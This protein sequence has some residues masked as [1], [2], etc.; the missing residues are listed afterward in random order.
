[1][2]TYFECLLCDRK[3]GTSTFG[4]PGKDT[5]ECGKKPPWRPFSRTRLKFIYLDSKSPQSSNTGD[6]TK[7]EPLLPHVGTTA[8]VTEGKRQDSRASQPISSAMN[9]HVQRGYP[10]NDKIHRGHQPPANDIPAQSSNS[11]INQYLTPM[12]LVFSRAVNAMIL[13]KIDTNI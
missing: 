2:S 3:Q 11:V 7:I 6:G 10:M 13:F 8:H 12:N 9:A 1:M 4:S 5:S